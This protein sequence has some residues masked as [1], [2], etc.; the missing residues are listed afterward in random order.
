MNFSKKVGHRF[1]QIKNSNEEN[2]GGDFRVK[3]MFMTT[4]SGL[5][6]RVV[7]AL[8][9]FL[10]IPMT[11]NY[12]GTE[13]YSLMTILISILTI[14]AYSDLG[15]GF[16]L[17]NRIPSLKTDELMLKK[18]VSSTFFFLCS[19]TFL[20]S[21][22][23]IVLFYIIDWRLVFNVSATINTSEIYSAVAS[24]FICI[25]V[26]IPFSFVSRVQNGFQ[27]GY[28]NELWTSI[29]S[30]FSLIA[31]YL[32]TANKL[33]IPWVILSLYGMPSIFM[34]FNFCV[35]FFIKRRFLFP[36]VHYIDK[37]LLYDLVKDGLV[38]FF[39]ALMYMLATSYDSILISHYLGAGAVVLYSIG[40]RLCSLAYTPV[41]IYTSS[42][43]PAFNDALQT[44]DKNWAK[45]IL[46]K[47]FKYILLISTGIAIILFFAFN[48]V[49]HIWI[50][51]DYSLSP[52]LCFAFSAFV[53][54]SGIHSLC[55]YTMLS[56]TFIRWLAKV[57]PVFSIIVLL[58]KIILIK[59]IG[60]EGLIWATIIGFFF[61]FH[62][63]SFFKLRSNNLI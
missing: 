13:R 58:L 15:L 35:H 5:F 41:N 31:L 36:S 57:F 24:F 47:S 17:Q 59:S 51:K 21:V 50:G 27:E 23:G 22:I 4:F 38:F 44:N 42:I 60:V 63:A 19:M 10:T 34:F 29:G 9:G 48:P 1:K 40:N 45:K 56:S 43:L 33:G 52:S 62:L 12:L 55:S 20:I 6:N 54:Y 32:V 8:V 39:I 25:I 30:V 3:R 53:I 28:M 46:T 7:T 14:V 18:A 26:A 11:L 2:G 49:I 61:T 16:G 37:A